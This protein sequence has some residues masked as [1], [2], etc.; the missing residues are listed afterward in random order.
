MLLYA[1]ILPD[2]LLDRLF[3]AVF[4]AGRRR[5]LTVC[6]QLERGRLEGTEAEFS[7]VNHQGCAFLLDFFLH[8][9]LLFCLMGMKKAASFN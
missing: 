5:I 7:A 3:A 8:E 4:Y 9:T 1:L 6:Q 2:K